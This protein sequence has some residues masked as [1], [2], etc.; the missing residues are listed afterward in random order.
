MVTLRSG[1]SPSRLPSSPGLLTDTV[2]SSP[3]G[4]ETD[5]T[6]LAYFHTQTDMYAGIDASS[7]PDGYVFSNHSM[8]ANRDF[9]ANVDTV[10][11]YHRCWVYSTCCG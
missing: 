11:G 8:F 2:T 10:C 9:Y 1:E 7:L 4:I 3:D 5:K 6:L